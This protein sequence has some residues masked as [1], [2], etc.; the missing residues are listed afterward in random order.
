MLLKIKK[1]YFIKSVLKNPTSVKLVNTKMMSVI[2]LGMVIM[3][4]IMMIVV[5]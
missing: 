5:I 1:L 2:A 3:M 4:M